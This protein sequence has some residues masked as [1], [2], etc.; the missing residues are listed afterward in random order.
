M[1]KILKNNILVFILILI[2]LV[3]AI[4]NYKS[5]TILSGWDTLHPEFN[6]PEYFKRILFGVW[7]E[8]QGLG[9]LSS[10]AHPSELPRML[11]YYPLSF[12]L[13]LS[14]LRY[15]Y[16]F[17][18]LI[19][20]P[21]GMYYFL[22]KAVL[23]ENSSQNKI[24]SFGGALFYLFNLGTIQHYF[25]PLEMFATHFAILPWL[26][27]FLLQYLDNSHKLYLLLSAIFTFFSAS[28][29]HTS[30]LWFAY[31][32]SL[33]L[34]LFAYNF[35]KSDKK[36]RINS[37][38]IIA[39]AL[40][41]NAFWL[42]PN[43]Y[44]I[45]NQGPHISNSKI[46]SLFTQEAFANNK[47]YG[48]MPDI[49]ILK[50]F[51]FN[52]N[53][54][55]GNGEFGPLLKAWINHLQQPIVLIIGY[56]LSLIAILGL[57][58]SVI[59]KNAISLCLLTIFGLAVFF[60]LT[61]NP[62]FG[63]LFS[64]LQ[65]VI[66]LFKEAIRF[67]FTKFS[68][69]LMFV[70]S[71]YFAFGIKLLIRKFS[72]YS[73]ILIFLAFLYYMF[74]AFQGNLISPLMK[75][76]IPSSYFSVFKLLN[77]QPYGRVATLPIHSFWGWNYYSWPASPPASLRGEQGGEYQGAGFL[78]FGLKDP[79]L[80]REFDRWNPA[81]EQYYREMSQAIYSQDQNKLNAV[82]TK[83]DISYILWDKSIIAPEQ[84][85]D[86]K[87]LFIPEITKLLNNDL[88]L[89]KEAQFGDLLVY[90]V[91]SIN[92]QV[93]IIQN[94][95]SVGPSAVFYDDPAYAKYHDY[96]TYSDA[97]RNSVAYPF[98][99]IIDNQNRITAKDIVAPLSFSE[100]L[101]PELTLNNL[102]ECAPTDL[103]QRK[104]S[105]KT[106]AYEKTGGFVEYS[107]DSASFCEHFSYPAFPRNQGYIIAINARNIQG[108]PLK[109]CVSNYLSKR[110]DLSAYLFNS[111][112]F[113]RNFFLI[114]PID[115][116][117]GFDININNFSVKGSPAIND[118]QTIEIFP[119]DYNNLSQIETY[120]VSGEQNAEKNVLVYSQAFDKGWK[121][122][123][124]EK[125][126]MKNEKY[127][128]PLISHLSS[129][130][131]FFFGKELKEHVLVNN[132]SNGWILNSQNPKT[133]DQRLI[134][135]FWPQYLEYLGFAILAGTF[136]VI[137]V[138]FLKR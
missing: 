76:N 16:F 106:I 15:S 128:S 40:L 43:L 77:N 25:V 50:N 21:L 137:F 113:T 92:P 115:Q 45:L 63:F 28:I 73:F 112:E 11:F 90:K 104:K 64:F 42:L 46:N 75:I 33:L 58:Y 116:S 24:A 117:I 118:L 30:T 39:V 38:K 6:F 61:D 134:I 81:N 126:E 13:P 18:T 111:K 67:P 34:F 121:A 129:L 19:F 101:S 53:A 26:F 105:F 71:A 79:V 22:K 107:S 47:L 80:E 127:L 66:P 98:R 69:L 27:L 135:I 60:L 20:G 110:C 109:I 95:V 12:L 41:I 85:K 91:K 96:I 35:I 54:Y 14:F 133:N 70:L 97:S 131:P 48:T 89:E 124:I 94:P 114:P 57:V 7:Q 123:E 122:Y 1:K 51:L 2:S 36:T 4:T 102:N 74:P 84:E 72:A 55:I 136:A 87:I 65:N 29:A 62:P 82:L 132:W 59:K 49:L 52:W 130:F 44:F 108:L 17:L 83:Y 78:W 125:G 56:G 9:A 32:F 86:K 88:A 99:N 5:G 93:R 37:V 10:Q 138:N 3:L 119:F 31:L 103:G 68:I 8:H 100:T 23:K 120:P